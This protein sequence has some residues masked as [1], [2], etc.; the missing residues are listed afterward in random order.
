VATPK[1]EHPNGHNLASRTLFGG[2]I[3]GKQ[4]PMA[5]GYPQTGATKWSYL[6]SRTLFGGYINGKQ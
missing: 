4:Q 2:Y 3:N 1:L 5:S 6:T